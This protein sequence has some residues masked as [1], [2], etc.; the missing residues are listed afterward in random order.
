MSRCLLVAGLQLDDCPFPQRRPF[1]APF[2]LERN[3]PMFD[4]G[5]R[6]H[7]R[8]EHV[9]RETIETRR[10]AAIVD[11]YDFDEQKIFFIR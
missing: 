3:L 7:R 2:N 1:V 6:L 4:D 5:E 8:L 9:G 11:T 10:L